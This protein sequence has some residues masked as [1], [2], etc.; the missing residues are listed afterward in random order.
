MQISDSSFDALF[1]SFLIVNEL[2]NHSLR[3][4]L[5]S[6]QGE[7]EKSKDWSEFFEALDISEKM[8]KQIVFVFVSL[9]KYKLGLSLPTNADLAC[10]E[11]WI[12]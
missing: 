12:Y 1:Q 9:I 8:S 7:I 4:T 10:Q 2:T 11:L 6:I 3:N 5:N